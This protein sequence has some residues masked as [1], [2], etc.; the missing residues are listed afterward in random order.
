MLKRILLAA[1][2]G[3][4]VRLLVDDLILVGKDK[5]LVAIDAHP[6]IEVRLFNPKRQ[7]RA[8]LVADSLMQFSRMTIR[9]HNKIIIADNQAVIL[10]GRNIG[11]HYYGLDHRFNFI[12]L[13]VLGFGP[14]ARQSSDLFDNF[15]NSPWAV[16]ADEIP[17]RVDEDYI[18]ARRQKL[19]GRLQESEDLAGFPTEP[20]NWNTELLDLSAKLR[21]GDSQMV[22]D[23]FEGD[24]IIR[25]MT[26]PLGRILQGAEKEIDLVN[27]YIIPNEGF[28]ENLQ[29]LTSSGVK[30][31]ILTNSLAS[32]D[33]PAVNSHYKKWREPLLRAGAELYELQAEPAVK[34]DVDTH[35]VV[36]KFTGLH[37]KAFVVD[38]ETLFVGSMNFDPRSVQINTEMG[39]I[40]KSPQLAKDL[41]ALADR[42]MS[43]ENAWQVKLSAEGELSWVSS[44]ETVTRQPAR[45]TWQRIQDA[46]FRLLPVDQL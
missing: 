34:K 18:Q 23:R 11:D 41:E 29:E 28:I 39:V 3:V 5:T 20:R 33:V 40:I 45:N 19:K 1:D 38:G 21:T 27:A 37:T 31:R 10:G 9:M 43:P 36:S 30:V 26:D 15:W 12:D 8:G 2:R 44:D 13:D 14:V 16:D 42:D 7:R 32:H 22:F 24:D 25:G 4:K 17:I 46:F 6:N 35:P